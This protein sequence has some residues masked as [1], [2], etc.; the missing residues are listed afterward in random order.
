MN[1]DKI[2]TILKEITRHII[3]H[4]N[5]EEICII[6]NHR[7]FGY[8]IECH[9]GKEWHI[10]G[11]DFSTEFD[12]YDVIKIINSMNTQDFFRQLAEFKEKGKI[13]SIK[14]EDLLQKTKSP[15]ISYLEL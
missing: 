2:K 14:F 8:N 13:N 7:S 3:L 5:F 9:C 15:T 12:S 4:D 6:Q 10:D 1:G 11:S